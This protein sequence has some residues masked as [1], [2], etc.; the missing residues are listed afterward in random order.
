MKARS[1]SRSSSE[2]VYTAM[3][4]PVPRSNSMP[5]G[6]ASTHTTMMVPSQPRSTRSSQVCANEPPVAN[7]GSSTITAGGEVEIEAT[8]AAKASAEAAYEREEAN[9]SKDSATGAITK[10]YGTGADYRFVATAGVVKQDVL[11]RIDDGATITGSTVSI[12][13]VGE[14]AALNN[15]L[16]Q[17]DRKGNDGTVSVNFSITNSNILTDVRGRVVATG[18]AAFSGETIHLCTG[19]Y[20]L[21]IGGGLVDKNL[22]FV[23]DGSTATIVDGG[24]LARLFDATD[25][26]VAFRA[27]ARKEADTFKVTNDRCRG[28]RSDA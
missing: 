16:I 7:I 21:A 1:F 28:R 23:G 8:G 13:S 25:R 6:A 20:D 10:T 2:A 3:S 26:T 4:R 14:N 27:I 12:K 17:N 24:G 9:E 5:S 22:T 15:A 11:T 18:A 19:T